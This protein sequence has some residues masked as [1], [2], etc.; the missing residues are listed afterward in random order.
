LSNI[1]NAIWYTINKYKKWR[2]RTSKLPRDY[3]IFVNNFKRIT[4]GFING[5]ELQTKNDILNVLRTGDRSGKKFNKKYYVIA[6]NIKR[7]SELAIE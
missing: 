5:I 3:R 1:K 2:T 7:T 6:Q 4:G